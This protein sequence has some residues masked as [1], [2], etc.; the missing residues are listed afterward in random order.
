[1]QRAGTIKRKKS[2]ADYC[3]AKREK[4]EQWD[5]KK[6]A[7][8]KPV[9]RRQSK[10][11]EREMRLYYQE[12]TEWLKKHPACQICAVRGM[13]PAPAT[14][15]HHI[16]GR[17][18]KLLRDQRFWCASCR[19]CREWPHENPREARELGVLAEPKDWNTSPRE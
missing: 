13:T 19:G 6:K 5:G 8:P 15:T 17:I 4:R 16:R 18:G 14:E 9:M 1:M 11:R 10:A 7:P 3:K 2:L 12:R